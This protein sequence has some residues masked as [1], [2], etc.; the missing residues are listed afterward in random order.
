MFAMGYTA[1]GTTRGQATTR[2][3]AVDAIR[4]CDEQVRVRGAA[5]SPLSLY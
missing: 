4:L 5:A 1:D 3:E 2:A